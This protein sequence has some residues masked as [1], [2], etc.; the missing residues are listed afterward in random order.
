MSRYFAHSVVY[1]YNNM[2]FDTLPS[3]YLHL[4]YY[5]V[6]SIQKPVLYSNKWIVIPANAFSCL[7]QI[8]KQ[9]WYIVTDNWQDAMRTCTRINN[10]W[11]YAIP[12]P[13]V[14]TLHAFGTKGKRWKNNTGQV[15]LCVN[16]CIHMYCTWDYEIRLEHAIQKDHH[17]TATG[18]YLY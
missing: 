16:V 3:L 11:R 10:A 5:V 18:K 6:W 4:N 14:M 7:L 13:L 9:M 12:S 1:G 8:S 2:Q 17:V 15:V